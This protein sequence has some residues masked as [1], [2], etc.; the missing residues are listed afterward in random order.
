MTDHPADSILVLLETAPDGAL[1]TSAAG[2]LA[3]A[4]QIGTPVALAVSAPG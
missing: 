4:A 1:A 3:A 2:L